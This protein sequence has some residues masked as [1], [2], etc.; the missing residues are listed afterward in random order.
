MFQPILTRKLLKIFVDRVEHVNYDIQAKYFKR[1]LIDTK[2]FDVVSSLLDQ[3]EAFLTITN[4][5][6]LF[7]TAD[8]VIHF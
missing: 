1:Y 8:S 5:N 4:K 3:S 6:S 2:A 7:L